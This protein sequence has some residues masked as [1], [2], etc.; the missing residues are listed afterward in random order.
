M[1]AQGYDVSNA[2]RGWHNG[3]RRQFS[4]KCLSA[5]PDL[6]NEPE[7]A[8]VRID[9]QGA[10]LQLFGQQSSGDGNAMG[11]MVGG[12]PHVVSPLSVG[13]FGLAA[14]YLIIHVA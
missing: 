5:I 8:G 14:A 3:G 7:H 12:E 11:A 10:A 2:A 4:P 9:R 1:P 6:I 13:N